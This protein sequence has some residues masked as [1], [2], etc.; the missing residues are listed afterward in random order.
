MAAAVKSDNTDSKF[1]H[2]HPILKEKEHRIA[3]KNTTATVSL[4]KKPPGVTPRNFKGTCAPD[5]CKH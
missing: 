2:M 5:G 3:K 1:G 4:L